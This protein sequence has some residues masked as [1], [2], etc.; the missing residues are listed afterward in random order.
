MPVWEVNFWKPQR[1]K[2]CFINIEFGTVR[3]VGVQFYLF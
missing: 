1:V 3:C 2:I